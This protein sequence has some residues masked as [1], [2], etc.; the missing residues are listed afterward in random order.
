M[1]KNESAEGR[2]R[3]GGGIGRHRDCTQCCR[4]RRHHGGVRNGARQEC[5]GFGDHGL[6]DLLTAPPRHYEHFGAL[7]EGACPRRHRPT[8]L[9]DRGQTNGHNLNVCVCSFWG[10]HW[11]TEG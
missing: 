11:Q 9:V 6:C 10:A 8:R 1:C 3:D 4:N 5:D 2:D 7:D